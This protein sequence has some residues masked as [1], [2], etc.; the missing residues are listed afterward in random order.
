[1]QVDQLLYNLSLN[2]SSRPHT[3]L[4]TFVSL[5]GG[6]RALTAEKVVSLPQETIHLEGVLL[7]AKKQIEGGPGSALR[8][9]SNP[10]IVRPLKA[11]AEQS[12]GSAEPF[13]ADFVFRQV[14]FS[15]ADLSALFV[16]QNRDSDV[17][18]FF[19]DCHFEDS[20]WA[21]RGENNA[22]ASG[23][24]FLFKIDEK[25]LLQPKIRESRFSASGRL[26]KV[27]LKN[28]KT[29]ILG[30]QSDLKIQAKGADV[31]TGNG[32]VLPG[33]LDSLSSSQQPVKMIS[34]TPGLLKAKDPYFTRSQSHFRRPLSSREVPR[35]GAFEGENNS[36]R[37][38][39]PH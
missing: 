2:Q 38:A 12:Q 31:G 9:K 21:S 32:F 11:P 35:K 19:E 10:V 1:M 37:G 29:T 4:Q 18:I 16:L 20:K 24:T 26:K 30:K 3:E 39:R 36:R 13:R 27:N 6:C 23:Q 28:L 7:Q 8:V 17:K 15:S 22:S 34:Q 33:K 5:G 14:N 25:A